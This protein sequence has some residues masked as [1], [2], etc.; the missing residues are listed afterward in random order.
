MRGSVI[1]ACCSARVL[2]LLQ[3]RFSEGTSLMTNPCLLPFLRLLQVIIE[4]I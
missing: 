1:S 4:G 2:L 3:A